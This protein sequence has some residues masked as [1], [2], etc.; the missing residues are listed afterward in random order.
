MPSALKKEHPKHET[1]R[2]FSTFVGHFCHPGSGSIWDPDPDKQ[3]CYFLLFSCKNFS[4]T[5]L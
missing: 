1:F 3:P 2:F 4:S 5:Y